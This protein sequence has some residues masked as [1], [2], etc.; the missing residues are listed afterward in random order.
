MAGEI[1]DSDKTAS[2]LE[3]INQLSQNQK[4]LAESLGQVLNVL[5]DKTEGARKSLANMGKEALLA[6]DQAKQ[7]GEQLADFSK[8][9]FKINLDIQGMASL[10]DA[11]DDLVQGM[12]DTLASSGIDLAKYITIGKATDLLDDLAEGALKTEKR[13]TQ[14]IANIS[15]Q[16]TGLGGAISDQ[17]SVA[18][19]GGWASATSQ[20]IEEISKAQTQL[21]ASS[22]DSS[23]AF[24]AFAA[25]GISVSDTINLAGGAATQSEAALGGLST[26]LA[27]SKAAGLDMAETAAF[28]A[29]NMRALGK[30]SAELP[31]TLAAISIAQSKSSLTMGSVQDSIM[32]GAESLKYYGTSVSDV[33]KTFER[34]ISSTARGKQQLGKE[35]FGEVIGGIGQMNLGL[36]AYLGMQSQIGR[37]TGATGSALRF[38]Q[39]IEEGNFSDIMGSI[40]SQ[41]ENFGG[42]RILTRKEAMATGQEDQYIMQRQLL[43]E[44]TNIRDSSK[45]NQLMDMMA[46]GRLE[47]AGKYTQEELTARQTALTISGKDI[48]SSEQGV[49]ATQLNKLRGEE[50]ESVSKLVQTYSEAN[51]TISDSLG[52]FRKTIDDM[53]N[54]TIAG[55][56]E[57]TTEENNIFLD[58]Q[59]QANRIGGGI[60]IGAVE[61]TAGAPAPSAKSINQAAFATSADVAAIASPMGIP[62]F[63]L[64]PPATNQLQLN[65]Q[66]IEMSNSFSPTI[67]PID[68]PLNLNIKLSQDSLSLQVAIDKAVEKAIAA[69]INGAVVAR[70]QG[71]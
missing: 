8:K 51:A 57:N 28:A 14:N 16:I 11:I 23:A 62:A 10:P 65:K 26:A 30:E 59:I 68:L 48:I 31:A 4:V 49:L 40:K 2:V 46:T 21:G 33:A 41:L 20:A 66:T 36:K 44:F 47:E 25:A 1:T 54:T 42:G 7:F 34:F 38:E 29:L 67:A 63:S 3:K 32:R 55:R 58:K 60:T 52:K 69:K 17:T 39:A 50:A 18:D 9:E 56:P 24:K 13:F 19:I 70:P 61:A 43:G 53:I 64:T 45:Q 15:D 27:M 22:Q 12:N 6:T 5:V 35:L 71:K 37:G